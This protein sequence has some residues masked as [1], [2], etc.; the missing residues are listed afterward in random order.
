[1][2]KVCVICQKE[3]KKG[4]PIKEDKIIG[5]IREIKRKLGVAKNNELY[6]CENDGEVH[7]KRRKSFEG[8]MMLASVFAGIIIVLT[9][10]A[11]MLSG[12]LEIW[13]IF[14]ALILAG[15]FILLPVFKYVP[16][17]QG[18]AKKKVK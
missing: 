9:I 7:A 4:T 11:I 3:I 12:K 6:V 1:M 17:I 5:T 2:A 15:F 8:S 10:V 18:A 16:A 14:A 13:S